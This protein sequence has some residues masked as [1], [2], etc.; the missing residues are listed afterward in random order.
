[1][2]DLHDTKLQELQQQIAN[3][4]Y[5]VHP[6]VLADAVLSHPGSL[7]ILT[8]R[9]LASFRPTGQGPTR[10]PAGRASAREQPRAA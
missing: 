1:M 5:R 9:Q 7:A 10:T 3:G 2:P 4:E 8:E 6:R